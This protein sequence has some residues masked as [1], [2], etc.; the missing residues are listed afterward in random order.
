M[1]NNHNYKKEYLELRHFIGGSKESIPSNIDVN[2]R[3]LI[4]STNLQE[5]LKKLDP[6]NSIFKLVTPLTFKKVTDYSQ[7]D[8]Q[9]FVCFQFNLS[10]TTN[11]NYYI[12]AK[13][14]KLLDK[15]RNSYGED[16]KSLIGLTHYNKLPEILTS[17]KEELSNF[18]YFT[19]KV[20][21][22]SYHL[23]LSYE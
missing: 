13:N 3:L 4:Q 19:D 14:T 15:M 2:Q 1:N 7:T 20:K 18:L 17:I 23:L 22:N 8:I 5:L 9:K 12:C 6:D 16:T 21:N 11:V 10:N